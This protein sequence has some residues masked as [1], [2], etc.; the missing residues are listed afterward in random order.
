MIQ[1]SKRKAVGCLLLVQLL[2]SAA[3]AQETVQ[4]YPGSVPNAKAS[5]HK[6]T[7]TSGMF[8]GVT[9]PT[10]EVYLPD[11]EKSTGAAAI[12][13]PGGSYAVV[14]YQGEGI[15]T[16]RQLAKNGVAAFVLKYRL[17]DDSIMQDKTTGPLQD[18][19]QAIKLVR[20]SAARW[21]ID[22]GKV[23]VIG[24]SAGGHLASTVATHFQNA[25]VNNSGNTSL[26][27]LI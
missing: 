15:A 4:L 10:L 21:G 6:E 2:L 8:R 1:T 13:I 9:R 24:F 17:P 18:A 23:G 12:I 5:Q 20:D 16:A 7:F 26:P 19:Q 3:S 27:P 25:L 11:K 22:A 14:V